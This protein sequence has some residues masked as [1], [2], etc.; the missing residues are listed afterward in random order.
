[1]F[2][3]LKRLQWTR[4]AKVIWT[5]NA[6]LL[7]VLGCLVADKVHVAWFESLSY[8]EKLQYLLTKHEGVRDEVYRCTS[9]CRTIGIGHNLEGKLS[10]AE[11][12][13]LEQ[14]GATEEQIQKWFCADIA[15]AENQVLALYGDSE[16]YQRLSENRKLILVDMCFNLGPKGLPKFKRM[17]AALERGDFDEASAEMLDSDWRKQTMNR[18]YRLADIMENDRYHLF[19]WL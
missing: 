14:N 11:I 8:T 2:E 18:A 7:V 16:W 1:M 17:M 9:G 6:L 19:W 12:A 13:A 3:R 5:I 10:E 15:A 4:R